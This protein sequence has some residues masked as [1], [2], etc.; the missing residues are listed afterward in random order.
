[1]TQINVLAV[2]PKM[3]VPDTNATVRLKSALRYDKIRAVLLGGL[4]RI[5]I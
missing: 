4:S 2:I 1:M 3:N 5:M